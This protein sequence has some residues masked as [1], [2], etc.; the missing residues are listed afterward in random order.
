MKKESFLIWMTLV[1]ALTFITFGANNAAAQDFPKFAAEHGY[2]HYS[3]VFSTT[4]E[5]ISEKGGISCRSQEAAKAGL[6]ML[7]MG[8]GD[9]QRGPT[10]Q[11]GRE[12]SR[13][14]RLFFL[15]PFYNA[16]PTHRN[17]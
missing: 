11:A 12:S 8:G 13:G 4:G 16:L 10:K 1:L 6:D 3:E 7:K 17:R 14:G 5:L 15:V 2:E 9:K